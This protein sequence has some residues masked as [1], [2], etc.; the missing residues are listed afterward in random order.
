VFCE[1]TFPVLSLF[2]LLPPKTLAALV[3]L[4]VPCASFAQPTAP[5]TLTEGLTTGRI[6]HVVVTGSKRLSIPEILS[7]ITEAAGSVYDRAAA[8]RDQA[9]LMATGLFQQVQV[10]PASTSAGGVDLTVAVSENPV[11]QAITFTA[12]TPGGRLPIPAETLRARMQTKV[13]QTLRTPMLT[14]DLNVLFNNE[15]GYA[16]SQGF[17]VSVS[18]GINIDPKNGTLTIPLVVSRVA[19]IDVLGGRRAAAEVRQGLRVKVDDVLNLNA[20]RQDLMQGHG[21]VAQASNIS[22]GTAAPGQATLVIRV[23]EKP[24]GTPNPSFAVPWLTLPNRWAGA[25]IPVQ[26]NGTETTSF[27]LNTLTPLSGISPELAARLHL[28]PHPWV[29]DGHPVTVES[30][31]GQEVTLARMRLGS[32]P[33]VAVTDEQMLLYDT[34]SLSAQ[35]GRPIDGILG[36][37]DLGAQAVSLD[38]DTR[39]VRFWER[40]NLSAAERQAAGFGEALALPLNASGMNSL[41]FTIDAQ[42]TDSTGSRPETLGL[43]VASDVNHLSASEAKSL[44][45]APFDDTSTPPT[46]FARP[47]L[48]TAGSLSVHDLAFA[49][50]GDDMTP[51]LG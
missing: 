40:G 44:G 20:L 21:A 27:V 31:P 34:K 46:P 14:H 3:L 26:I 33:G 35:L 7:H 41:L 5:Y 12:D 29:V 22:V 32:G 39:Q 24:E 19:R 18:N 11:V 45:A 16:R 51:M 42:L 23:Q 9:A 4:G 6:A 25:V 36:V 37:S 2:R 28:M 1:R 13:G 49:L 47:K 8:A 38:W 50:G 17:L 10:T 15:T 43:A 48:L 30:Q